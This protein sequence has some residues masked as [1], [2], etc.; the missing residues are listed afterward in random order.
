MLSGFLNKKSKVSEKKLNQSNLGLYLIM[1]LIGTSAGFFIELIQ[2]KFIYQ[3][4]Y[5]LEDIIVNGIGTVFGA[6]GYT[7]IG[8][9]L[10]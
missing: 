7:L 2:E 4:Y 6:F 8:R 9:K 5:D 10:V 1:I 3:R